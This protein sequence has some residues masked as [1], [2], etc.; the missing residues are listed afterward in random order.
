[1]AQQKLMKSHRRFILLQVAGF[2]DSPGKIKDLLRDD[3]YAARFGF[4]PVCVSN[5]AVCQAI[6]KLVPADVMAERV[7]FLDDFSDTPLAHR[8]KRVEA[9]VKIFIAIELD[10]TLKV[11]EQYLL[12]MKALRDIRAE[13]GEDFDKL[14]DAIRGSGDTHIVTIYEGLPADEQEQKLRNLS[15]IAHRL[16][17][18]FRFSGN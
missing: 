3:D 12:Q 18:R 6:K 10:K 15:Q 11:K 1:M 2:V 16:G 7:R 13:I 4:N 8:K 9:L 5:Q 17:D 14:V